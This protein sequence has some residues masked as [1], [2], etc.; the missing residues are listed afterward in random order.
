[1]AAASCTEILRFSSKGVR[2]SVVARGYAI[3]AVMQAKIRLQISRRIFRVG[4]IQP[5]S[6]K[7]LECASPQRTA[8]NYAVGNSG[9][10]SGKFLWEN[11]F[12]KSA[13]GIS[14]SLRFADTM[15]LIDFNRLLSALLKFFLSLPR[16]RFKT[17]R[18]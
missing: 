13:L 2:P 8:G 4:K 5:R 3:F 12:G 18:A 1:M 9:N 11:Y 7:A 16:I 17:L 10:S 14:K 15:L 6:E